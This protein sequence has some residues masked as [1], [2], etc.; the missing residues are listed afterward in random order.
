VE[1][2]VNEEES[3]QS[4]NFAPYASIAL[5]TIGGFIVAGPIGGV[6]GFAVGLADEISISYELTDK[7]YL[8]MS[9]FHYALTF[10]PY[11]NHLLKVFPQHKS[12]I[13]AVAG[14]L[15]FT[16]SHYSDDFID[17]SNKINVPLDA[18]L[19]L[20][21]LF[22][23]K[24]IISVKEAKKIYQEFCNNP[25]NAIALINED[26][27]ELKKN[28]FLVKFMHKN[29]LSITEVIGNQ[30]YYRLM[31]EYASGILVYT[32]L[33]KN[34][35]YAE[36]PLVLPALEFMFDASKAVSLS[37]FRNYFYEEI[38]SRE[39]A[40]SQL[41]RRIMVSKATDILLDSGNARKI[42]SKDE[43]EGKQAIEYLHYD[44]HDLAAGVNKLS[45][46]LTS[47]F[48]DLLSMKGLIS[49]APDYLLPSV[50]FL[51]MKQ[52]Q[53]EAF[54]PVYQ[55]NAAELASVYTQIYTVVGDIKEKTEEIDLRDGEHFIKT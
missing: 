37:L 10:N 53:A 2:I 31:G 44:L 35:A 39:I 54:L 24:G 51:K 49:F 19:T 5:T 36:S 48:N 20:N 22:D 15:S 42:L 12:P 50:L 8:G 7:H 26:I 25:S 21:K 9:A 27:S 41:E 11:A 33:G 14:A 40:L 43:H 52:N 4:I 3:V 38:K 29:A 30:I 55:E 6:L 1:N 23:P 32:L 46:V 34:I 18:F 13:N 45:N 28:E 17:F 47:L 16:I